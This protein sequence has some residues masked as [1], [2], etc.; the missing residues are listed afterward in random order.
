MN[1]HDLDKLNIINH[2]AYKVVYYPEHPNAWKGSGLVYF[3]RIVM[4]NNINRYLKRSECVHHKDSNTHNND[5]S[6]L[7]VMTIAE[8]NVLHNSTLTII[9]CSFC[10]KMFK[11][12]SSSTLFCSNSCARKREVRVSKDELQRL[13]YEKPITKIASGY[14]VSDSA[15]IKW[16]K[17]LSVKRPGRGYWAKVRA[18]KLI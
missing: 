18:G 12:C 15:V 16:C 5:I 6:N 9:N 3:H 10:K 2:K 7:E 13:V 1:L 4:E 8:H 14:G 11:P 17:K